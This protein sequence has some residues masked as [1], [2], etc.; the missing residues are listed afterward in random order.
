MHLA[1]FDGLDDFPE[2]PLPD[3]A[4]DRLMKLREEASA[5]LEEARREKVIG[6]SLEGAIALGPSAAL[7]DDRAATGTTGAGLADLFIVSETIESPA[8]SGEAGWTESRTYPG[9]ALRFEKARGRRC[10]R[11]WKVTPE[12]DEGGLCE[13]CRRAL[14]LAAAAIS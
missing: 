1:G 11:C 5:L 6:S 3:P 10:D 2:D 9:L 4:W 8:G 7:D 12:A 13:R 14:A